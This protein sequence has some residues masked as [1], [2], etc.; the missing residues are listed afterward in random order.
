MHVYYSQRELKHC[1]LE[2]LRHFE[3]YPVLNCFKYF[4]IYILR[5]NVSKSD[6]KNF[7]SVKMS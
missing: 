6:K 2:I 5:Q 4:V 7:I 1:G 3:L